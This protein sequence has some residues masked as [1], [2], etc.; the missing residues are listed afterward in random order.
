MS[1]QLWENV[2]ALGRFPSSAGTLSFPHGPGIAFPVGGGHRYAAPCSTPPTKM[3][4]A[5]A[6]TLAGVLLYLFW[7]LALIPHPRNCLPRADWLESGPQTWCHGC[8]LESRPETCGGQVALSV[9]FWQ[10]WG[11]AF[12]WVCREVHA[13]GLGATIWETPAWGPE[14][15][16]RILGVTVGGIL[17]NAG[18]S[19]HRPWSSAA[20]SHSALCFS[21][22]SIHTPESGRWP[23]APSIW[24]LSS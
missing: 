19:H 18:A 16:C 22:W 13:A 20:H 2:S 10:R 15:N 3:F 4:P 12:W 7:V 1:S 6:E 11:S 24:S 5:F 8:H 23:P 9:G 21:I 14:C 17:W